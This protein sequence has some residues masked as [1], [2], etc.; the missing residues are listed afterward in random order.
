MTARLGRWIAS[1]NAME[2]RI[3]Q[4]PAVRCY[5]RLVRATGLVLEAV[6]LK[7]PIGAACLIE[8]TQG[9]VITEIECEVVGFNGQKMFLMPLEEME[10]IV[11]G[12]RV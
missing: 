5:G 10:G 12:A 2:E 3:S 1:L 11:P 4:S 6:G 8:R 7:L 9:D